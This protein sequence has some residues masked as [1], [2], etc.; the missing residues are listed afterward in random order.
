MNACGVLVL[1]VFGVI[2]RG[3]FDSHDHQDQLTGWE[4]EDEVYLGSR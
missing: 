2:G 3:P 1:R 4:R